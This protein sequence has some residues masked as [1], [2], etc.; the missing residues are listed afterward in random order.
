[1]R[2]GELRYSPSAI[3]VL[4]SAGEYSESPG[5]IGPSP[6]ISWIGFAP[7]FF[8]R[9]ICIHEIPTY[10]LLTDQGTPIVG[11]RCQPRNVPRH[12]QKIFRPSGGLRRGH[13]EHDTA[14]GQTDL[15]GREWECFYGQLDDD[16]RGSGLASEHKFDGKN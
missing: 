16:R 8:L 1:M 14:R 4:D 7:K 10:G 5:S 2:R 12:F 13:V 15:G 11:F 6:F 9:I 3:L